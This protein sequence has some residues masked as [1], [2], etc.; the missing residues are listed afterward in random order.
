MA[1]AR[2]RKR[3][4]K[5]GQT[6]KKFGAK[7][8]YE[9]GLWQRASALRDSMVAIDPYKRLKTTRKNPVLGGNQ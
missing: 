5:L 4:S 9:A 1:R 6:P 7:T 2:P 8:G 3:R